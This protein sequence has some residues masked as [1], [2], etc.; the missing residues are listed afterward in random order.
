[1]ADFTDLPFEDDSLDLIAAGLSI[2]NVDPRKERR[3][4]R[5]QGAFWNQVVVWS[6]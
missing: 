6:F 3:R 2:Y 1:M 5:K 4:I